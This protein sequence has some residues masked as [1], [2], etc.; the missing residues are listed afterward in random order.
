MIDQFP[1]TTWCSLYCEGN[2]AVA[3]M[4]LDYGDEAVVSLPVCN[5]CMEKIQNNPSLLL[6]LTPVDV[7]DLETQDGLGNT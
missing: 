4:D 2:E 1:V 5:E 3:D 7:L 6:D